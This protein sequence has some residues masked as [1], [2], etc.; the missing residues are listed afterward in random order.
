MPRY[1]EL[2]AVLQILADGG[3]KILS[4]DVEILPTL[5]IPVGYAVVPRQLTPEMELAGRLAM[6][7]EHRYRQEGRMLKAELKAPRDCVPVQSVFDAILE[8]APK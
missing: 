3:A 5:D 1:V 7:V 4:P 6:P 8:A 2:T